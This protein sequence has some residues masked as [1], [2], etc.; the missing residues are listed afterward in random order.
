MEMF[1]LFIFVIYGFYILF[2]ISGLFR[3]NTIKSFSE[4]ELPSASIII[5]ARNEEKNL[6][7]LIEDLSKQDYP[8]DKLE[9]IISEPISNKLQM[10]L[11]DNFL[12]KSSTDIFLIISKIDLGL[13]IQYKTLKFRLSIGHF[14]INLKK[15]PNLLFLIN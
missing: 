10:L 5:A 4:K 11:I 15:S 7:N 14:P 12:E 1:L 9:I 6:P 2:I 8:L 3:H 13:Y